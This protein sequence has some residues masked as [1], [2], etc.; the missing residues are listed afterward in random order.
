MILLAIAMGALYTLKEKW[1]LLINATSFVGAF[2]YCLLIG[3]WFYFY[4]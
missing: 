2:A 1:G 3:V 4:S